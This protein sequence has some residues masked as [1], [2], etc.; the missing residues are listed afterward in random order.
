MTA[1][2]L[3]RS[4][5]RLAFSAA[6]VFAWVMIFE[7]LALESGSALVGLVNVS[8]VYALAHAIVVLL[9]PLAA[10]N[11][12]N[13]LR[14]SLVC[15]TL[16]A[17]AAFAALSLGF[18]VGLSFHIAIAVFAI[19]MGIYRAMYYVSYEITPAS[20]PVWIEILL[21]LAPLVVGIL[22]GAAYVAPSSLFLAAAAISLLSLASF[23]W[24]PES[25]EGFAWRYRETFHQLFAREHRSILL[26][27]FASG[28]E[29]AALLLIWPI[30]VLMILGGSFALLGIVLSLT[31]LCTLLLR[32][33]FKVASIRTTPA[34]SSAV[35]ASAWV[36]RVFAANGFA[37]VL[38]DAYMGGTTPH[39]GRGLDTHTYEQVADNHTYID[40]MTALKEMGNALGRTFLVLV[41][42]I[43][44]SSG[45]FGASILLA[46]LIAAIAGVTATWLIERQDR[47]ALV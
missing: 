29:A 45:D 1:R 44:A 41:I 16:A 2:L 6:H 42:A 10:R 22:I 26:A 24:T 34:V 5:L 28:I 27:S 36:L 9:T 17:A 47:R 32:G 14:R 30:A 12:R 18:A 35:I 40:E 7:Y 37:V 23:A 25:H 46:F 3:H 43:C 20:R 11:L 19:L 13:G 21:A 39:E 31:L 8:L 38:I 15:G 4:L 33:I